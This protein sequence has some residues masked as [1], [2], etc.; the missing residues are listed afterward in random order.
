[1]TSTVLDS[2]LAFYVAYLLRYLVRYRVPT[3]NSRTACVPKQLVNAGP[4]FIVQGQRGFYFAI[5]LRSTYSSLV[6]L[7]KRLIQFV[8]KTCGYYIDIA[9]GIKG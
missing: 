3:D 2:S 6:D 7:I 4:S 8:I 1:M 9:G 5:W